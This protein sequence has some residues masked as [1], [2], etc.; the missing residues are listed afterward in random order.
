MRLSRTMGVLPIDK[1]L[2][3]NQFAMIFI[4]KF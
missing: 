3:S 4:P 2:S 1:E